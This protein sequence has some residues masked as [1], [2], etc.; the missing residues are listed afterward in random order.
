MSATVSP[1]QLLSLLTTTIKARLPLLIVGS[2]GVGKSDIIAEA[3]RLTNSKLLLSHPAVSDP[4]D[5]RGLPWPDRETGHAKFLPFGDLAQALESK[6]PLVWALDDLGQATPA[7]QASFMQLLLARRVND[8]VLPDHVVFVAATNR[9][10]D[11]AGVSGMLEPVKSRFATIVQ[12]EPTIDDWTS[13]AYTHD[14]ASVVIGFLRFRPDLLNAFKPT[15]DLTNSPSP[16]TWASLSKLSQQGLPDSVAHAAYCG[17][18]GEGAASEFMAFLRIQRSLPELDAIIRAPDS[19]PIPTEVSALFAVCTG[20]A[21]RSN[22][23]NIAGISR[24]V[25]R[26]AAEGHGEFAVLTARDALKRDQRLL[27]TP[28]F[29]RLLGGAI[30]SLITGA[31]A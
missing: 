14:I 22:E 17:A 19:A 18:V 26:L 20:L 4:T 29:R 16:R 2:P 1:G 21:H 3:A 8:K 11:R 15:G 23:N 7:V 30:G 24:Y 12:L 25:E 5:A 28:P 13:W 6:E 31:A 27:T 9:R 10:E